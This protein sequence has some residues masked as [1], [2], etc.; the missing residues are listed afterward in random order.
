VRTQLK[1]TGVFLGILITSIQ[2]LAALKPLSILLTSSSGGSIFGQPVVLTASL[3]SPVAGQVTFYDGVAVLGVAQGNTGVATLTTTLLPAGVRSLKAFYPGD[4]TYTSATSPAFVFSVSTIGDGNFAAARLNG[5]GGGEPDGVIVAD[6]NGDGKPDVATANYL[7][8]NL[9]V[10]IGVGDGTFDNAANFP[11]DSGTVALATGDFN[12][13]GIAD[14]ATANQ[15][16]NTFSVLLGNGN[17]TFSSAVNYPAPGNPISIAI[18][19]LNGDGVADIAVAN[20]NSGL[21][22]VWLGNG[23]GTFQATPISSQAGE[24]G[25]SIAFADLN[26]DGKADAVIAGTSGGPLEGFVSVLLGKGNGSSAAPVTYTAGKWPRTIAL[27]DFN[28]DGKTDVAVANFQPD[29]QGI[30]SVSV[31]LGNGDGS[32]GTAQNFPVPTGNPGPLTVSD[33]N[34]DGKLDLILNGSNLIGVMYGNGDGTFQTPV[35]YGNLVVNGGSMS[36][37]EFG[38]AVADFNGDGAPDVVVGYP[39]ASGIVSMIG[40]PS[41]PAIQSESGI[42]N[43]ANFTEGLASGA[44][45]TLYG[46]NLATSVRTW[47]SSDFNGDDLPTSIDGVQ[48]LVNGKSAYINYVSPTQLNFL[49][50]QDP[51]TGPVAVQVSNKLGV[52]SPVSTVKQAAAPAFFAYSVDSGRYA[53]AQDG[54]TYALLAP[55]GLLGSEVPTHP[56]AVGE[57][58]TLYAT[59]LGDTDPPYADGTI[60]QNALPLPTPPTVLIGGV[61]ATVQFAGIVEA[62]LYQINLEI[63]NVASGDASIAM[64]VNGVTMLGQIFIAIK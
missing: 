25:Q 18:A 30:Y 55:S 17:G 29:S 63:P 43:G 27:G 21:I 33:I 15:T 62:G 9:S 36:F 22:N 20:E 37:T 39:S 52:S 56:A 26:G 46:V 64:T 59:G 40:L 47:N 45:M 50:P 28:G 16:A 19:D 49:A 60:I 32:L 34:G 44:W 51:A 11:T 4:P 1:M 48:V 24:L 41:M 57:V 10:Y 42:V 6:L 53:I 23:N 7:G 12:G 38:L 58:V 5:S 54:L 14:I 35:G 3:S 13:D 31:F 2:G 61:P 8:N